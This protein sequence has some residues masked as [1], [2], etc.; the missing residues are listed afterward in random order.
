[1]FCFVNDDFDAGG[2]LTSRRVGGSARV[3][4]LLGVEYEPQG[5]RTAGTIDEGA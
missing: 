2:E 4:V 5:V 1:M 3:F